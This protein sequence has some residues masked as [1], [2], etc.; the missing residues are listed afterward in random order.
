MVILKNLYENKVNND[1]IEELETRN[2][3]VLP[4][5]Y[6][7]FILETNGGT[8]DQEHNC[9]EISGYYGKRS[10][11]DYLDGIEA[12][13]SGIEEGIIMFQDRLPNGFIPIGGDPGGNLIC[14]GINMPYKD[15]IFYWD[16]EDELDKT[17]LSKKDMSNMYWVADDIY[18]FLEKL[19][20]AEE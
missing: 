9:F 19:K 16:H 3:I 12:P 5:K 10:L 13:L 1:D 2:K 20:R 15:Q 17:G 4:A 6:K 18:G 7:K 14:L 11:L 8:P